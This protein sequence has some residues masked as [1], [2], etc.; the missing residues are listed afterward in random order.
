MSVLQTWFARS[1]ATSA[2][3]TDTPGAP[4]P[5]RSSAGCGYIAASPIVRISRCTRLRLTA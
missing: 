1:I 3:N 5:A 2:A 4:A